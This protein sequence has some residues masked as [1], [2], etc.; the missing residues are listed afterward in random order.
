MMRRFCR[1]GRGGFD[2]AFFRRAIKTIKTPFFKETA[3]GEGFDR[4][5]DQN[6][7]AMKK[8]SSLRVLIA[9]M[10]QGGLFRE[11]RHQVRPIGPTIT[12]LV[13]QEPRIGAAERTA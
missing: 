13:T 7:L 2:R 12:H 9:F 10:A 3:V 11:G 8:S 4:V 1:S 6:P 5:H